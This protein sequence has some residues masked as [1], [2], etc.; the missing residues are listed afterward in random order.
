M[1]P[2]RPG[3]QLPRCRFQCNGRWGC[4]NTEVLSHSGSRAH[5]RTSGSEETE[6]DQKDSLRPPDPTGP[7]RAFCYAV[8][9]GLAVAVILTVLHHVHVVWTP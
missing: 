2:S 8:L 4:R 7:A 6:M 9:A 5:K 1:R 3:R